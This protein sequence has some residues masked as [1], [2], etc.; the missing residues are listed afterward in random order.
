M[1]ERVWLNGRL[2][3]IDKAA[4]SPLDRGFLYGD[5]LF[6]TMRS[7]DGTIHLLRRHL[8]RLADSAS[9]ID[10]TLPTSDELRD[11]LYALLNGNPGP[12]SGSRRIRLTVSRGV[13]L[14]GPPTI[15]ARQSPIAEPTESPTAAE[16]VVL[17]R[18][19]EIPEIY[20]RLKSLN[21]L[22]E[23][24]SRDELIS[25]GFSE[26]ILLSPEG[27][28]AEG[29]ISSIFSV[30]DGD[31]LTPPIDLGILPGITRRRIMELAEALGYSVRERR[32]TLDE[33]KRGDEC[34]YANSVREL[35]PVGKVDGTQIGDGDPGPITTV[36]MNA[37]RSECPDENA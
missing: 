26:G 9:R 34:F 18:L 35:V 10:L 21:Y 5:G 24:H 4:I 2:T 23:I 13:D 12:R 32:F 27:Y 16:L 1:A 7:Y 20:P 22:P 11:I 3:S 33:L 28:V 25:R 36:V 8:E 14:A 30:V 37:Y 19:R 29:T 15:F 6:E 17:E 31:L